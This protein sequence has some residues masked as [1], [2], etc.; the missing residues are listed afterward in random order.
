MRW[1]PSLR[2]R[3]GGLFRRF[4]AKFGRTPTMALHRKGGGG[5][6]GAAFAFALAAALSATSASA[7]WRI[8]LAALSHDGARAIVVYG[9]E[10][11]EVD[12]ATARTE[13][14]TPP[15]TCS[16]T[17]AAYAPK[18]GDFALT[19]HCVADLACHTVRAGVWVTSDI[20]GLANVARVFGKRWNDAVWR[21]GPG[22]D[23]ILLRET[24]I[25]RPLALGLNDLG[26]SDGCDHGQGRFATVSLKTA[27]VAGFDIAPRGWAVAAPVAA[28]ADRIVAALR[29]TARSNSGTSAETDIAALCAAAPT[30]EED[31]R[32][33]VCGE[34]GFALNFEWRDGDWRLI[35]AAEDGKGRLIVSTDLST[36]AK[37]VCEGAQVA[38]RLKAQ[39]AARIDGPG[40]TRTI[41]APEGLFG[42]IA[43]SG[44]GRFFASL[45]A[46]RGLSIRRFDLFDLRTGEMTDLSALLALEA[47]WDAAK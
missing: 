25:S 20:A 39:C 1:F 38:G 33:P 36:R 24:P 27:R 9:N 29:A 46:G 3:P 16:W 17:S 43:L 14:L 23:E 2:A 32:A 47:P 4:A 8:G 6:F 35:D 7:A 26:A 37:E 40:G 19:A 21:V 22:G 13:L 10:W 41:T 5:A 44:D 18:G 45:A 34:A 42:D 15:P 31:W 12:L 30:A 28:D 11:V